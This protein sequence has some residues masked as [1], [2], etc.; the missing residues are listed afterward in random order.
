ME[1]L[2]LETVSTAG[3]AGVGEGTGSAAV[4]RG[5]GRCGCCAS[6]PGIID[7]HGNGG[8]LHESVPCVHGNLN[9]KSSM[10][11]P[12]LHKIAASEDLPAADA[13]EAMLSF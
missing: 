6:N 8:E 5:A 2:V 13:Y 9:P 1:C 3:G 11:L 7:K 4:F 12:F 10:L